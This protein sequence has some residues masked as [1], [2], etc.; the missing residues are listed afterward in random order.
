MYKY[1]HHVYIYIHTSVNIYTYIHMYKYTHISTEYT[2]IY[3]HITA[4][5]HGI[6]N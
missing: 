4:V 1:T 3:V 5:V 2:C 6:T